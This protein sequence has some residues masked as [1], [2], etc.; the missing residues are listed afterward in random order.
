MSSRDRV[1]K[2]ISWNYIEFFSCRQEAVVVAEWLRRLTRNPLGYTR[3]EFKGYATLKMHRKQKNR[4]LIWYPGMDSRSRV[5]SRWTR[6]P[7]GDSQDAVVVAEILT[8]WTR[9][10]L[11][12][13]SVEFKGYATLKKHRRQQNRK[14]IWYPGMSSRSRVGRRWT[15]NPM[16]DSQVGFN[17]TN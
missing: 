8:R 9:N 17:P 12:Y 3:L 13:S 5:C 6:N 16:G 2:A 10:S 1:V 15:R 4:K 11:D 14:L 7:M